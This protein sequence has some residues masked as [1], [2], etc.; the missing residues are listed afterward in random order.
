MIV[1]QKPTTDDWLMDLFAYQQYRHGESSSNAWLIR[2]LNIALKE[3]LSNVE[4]ECILSYYAENKKMVEIA[5]S[6]G[7]NRSSVS[8]NIKRAKKKLFH[9][10]K[11]TNARLLREGALDG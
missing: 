11:Y 1:I 8:R 3:E 5:A 4:R 9:V 6:R 10:L 2:A 7:C